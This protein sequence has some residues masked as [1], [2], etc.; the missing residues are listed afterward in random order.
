MAMDTFLLLDCFGL[1]FLMYVL[2]NFWN[3]ERR[4]KHRGQAERSPAPSFDGERVVKLP[5][6]QLYAKH[7]SSVIP[8]PARKRQTNFSSE[9]HGKSAATVEMSK[10][11]LPTLGVKRA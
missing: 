10:R 8:F 11:S 7:G 3:E 6:V 5:S 2:A 4:F 9:Q 1:V